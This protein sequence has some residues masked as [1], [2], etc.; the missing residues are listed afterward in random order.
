MAD[1]SWVLFW[2]SHALAG[3]R[4]IVFFLT[5]VTALVIYGLMA[6]TPLVP[7]RLF[8]PLILFNP[9]AALLLLP[10]LIYFYARL[11][12]MAWSV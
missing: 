3:I 4:A 11:P 10:L 12:L 9:L 1:D 2:N 6:L 5:V 8:L 7:K